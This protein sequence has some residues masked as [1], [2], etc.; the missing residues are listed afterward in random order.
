MAPTDDPLNSH[1]SVSVPAIGQET[2]SWRPRHPEIF[3]NAETKRQTGA[4]DSTITPSIAAW[5]ADID[6][7]LGAELE[8]ASQALQKFDLYSL[9]RLATNSPELGPMSTILLRTESASSSQIEQLSTSARQLALAEIDESEKQN[10]LTVIGNVRAME[11]ALRLSERLDRDSILAMHKELL[12]HQIDMAEEAGR[13]REELVWIGGTD[14]AGPLGASFIAAQHSRVVPAIDDLVVFMN[15]QD[16]PALAQIAIAHAQ[17][18]TIHPFVD[19]NG[20][21]GRA[22][23]QSMLRNKKLSMHATA[24]ISAGILRNTSGYFDAL[25]AYRAGDA[26]PIIRIFVNASIYA[27][28]TGEMLV[29]SL[30]AQVDEARTRLQGLRSNSTAWKVLPLL[31]G[32]PVINARYL[33]EQLEINDAVAHRALDI[34]SDRGILQEKSGRSRNRVWQHQGIL[35]VLDDYAKDIRRTVAQD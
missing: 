3:S 34:L 30:A 4:Y 35:M 10:A 20:R 1:T 8:Q 22:L 29:D 13:F 24:P 19:G 12:S 23:A 27:A 26:A 33:K 15:R 9:L 28:A 11:A 21:T 31:I 17:F 7:S 5:Q 14:T 18:E 6:T 16:I 2:L 25:D 32:Q